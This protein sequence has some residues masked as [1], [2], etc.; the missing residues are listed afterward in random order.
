[1]AL[2]ALSIAVAVFNYC[3]ELFTEFFELDDLLVVDTS[4]LL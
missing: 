4:P 1:L 3:E 2:A